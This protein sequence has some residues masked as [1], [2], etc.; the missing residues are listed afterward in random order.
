MDKKTY[1]F[2]GSVLRFGKE[3]ARNYKATTVAVSQKKAEA[4]ICYQY[5]MKNGLAPRTNVSLWGQFKVS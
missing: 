5:K 1:S 2:T 3:V 4:N